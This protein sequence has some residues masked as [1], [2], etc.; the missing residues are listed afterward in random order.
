MNTEV[1]V[2]WLLS[3]STADVESFTVEGERANVVISFVGDRDIEEMNEQVMGHL[4]QVNLCQET[5]K[6]L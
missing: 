2:F 4:M 5:Y 6:I 3:C 1:Q